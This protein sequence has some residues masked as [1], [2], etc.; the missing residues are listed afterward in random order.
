MVDRGIFNDLLLEQASSYGAII[1]LGKR[2]S[3]QEFENMKNNGILIGA[4][5]AVSSVAKHF[6][7]G[8]MNNYVL[9]YKA[10]YK[11]KV[12]D[13]KSVDLFFDK[14]ISEGLFGWLCP[15]SENLLEVGIGINSGKTSSKNAFHKFISKTEVASVLENAELINEYASVIPMRL[16]KKLVDSKN[17]VLLI[18]DAAGQVKPSTGGGIVFG[19]NAAIIAADIIKKYMN[20][21]ATLEEYEK[22][23]KKRYVF[24]TKIHSILNMFYSNL[25]EKGLGLTMRLLNNLGMSG[26]LSEYGDMDSPKR[27]IKNILLRKSI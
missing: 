27:T 19:G 14:K 8:H 6:K 23:Y 13:T 11:M 5:G 12:C 17:R 20:N 7:M 3:D 16:R 26:F 1:S 2:I 9:T 4:D 15:N 10:E 25:G 18:G 21:S 24:D 22:I